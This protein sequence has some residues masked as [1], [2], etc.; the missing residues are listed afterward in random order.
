[1]RS[2]GILGGGV[3]GLCC[4]YYLERQGFALTVI[5]KGD[6]TEG[7]SWINAG[8]VVPSH[9]VPLAAPGAVAKGLGWM[10]SGESPFAIRIKN[11]A[12]L[13]RWLWLFYRHSNK[14]H[15][16]RAV[17]LLRDISLLS[18]ALYRELD[19]EEGLDFDY[20]ERGLLML[21]QTATA[22]KEEWRAAGH[23]NDAGVEAR[24][25][26]PDQIGIMEPGVCPQVRGGIYFPG[27]AHLNPAKFMR[28]MKGYLK[29]KGVEFITR[30]PVIGFEHERG[31]I[32]KI[33]TTNTEH[34]FDECIIACGSQSAVLLKKLGINLPLLG[35]K[36]YSFDLSGMAENIRIPSLLVEGRV[37]VTPLG[38]GSLRVGG[39][40]ILGE[41][42][43]AISATRVRGIVKTLHQFYPALK[44]TRISSLQVSAGQRPCSPDGLPYIGRSQK[45]NNL[46]IATGHGMMG[47]SLGPATGKLISKLLSADEPDVDLEP[48]GVERFG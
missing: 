28:N 15:V 40:M 30:T 4:A 47:M 1:M 38:P 18:K 35:G 13:L 9:I 23:A 36:G 33:K 2:V 20:Q 16:K 41:G 10:F 39:T 46:M 11:D 5:D 25:L 22:E 21:Y 26:S 3:V 31:W 19:R 14:A 42:H 24:I 8:M 29:S 37:S 45:Y 7:C 44:D 43:S 34:A 48:F 32:R 6:M 17:P 12:A 27:D